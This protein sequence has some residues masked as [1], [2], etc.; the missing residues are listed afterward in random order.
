MV[1]GKV[2]TARLLV[3]PT[4]RCDEL[5][6]VD[7]EIDEILAL[8]RV[9]DDLIDAGIIDPVKGEYLAALGLAEDGSFVCDIHKPTSE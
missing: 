4:D 8:G 3:G 7:L 5:P 9:E 2:L 1:G 6:V